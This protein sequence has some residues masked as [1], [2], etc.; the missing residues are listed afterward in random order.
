MRKNLYEESLFRCEDDR[1]ELDILLESVKATAKR[2][3]ELIDSMN[4]RAIK[5]ESSFRIEDHLTGI[6]V[7]CAVELMSTSSA[8]SP[9]QY[10]I[11]GA[12]G[13]D[14]M[15]ALRK[16]APLALPVILN[17]LK[18]KQGEWERCCVDF[19]KVWAEIYAK[20]YHKSLDHRTFYFKQQDTKNLT[21]KGN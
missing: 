15:D 21:A 11:C 17:R 20:N 14:V 16:N 5:T 3:E 7:Y 1:F 18:Q 9:P 8:F 4:V 10:L 19:N 6:A 12:Y 13:L 2:V